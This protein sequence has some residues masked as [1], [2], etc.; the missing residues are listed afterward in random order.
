MVPCDIRVW[1]SRI[2]RSLVDLRSD[3][4]VES[5]IHSKTIKSDRPFAILLHQYHKQF[6]LCWLSSCLLPGS[7]LNAA[8]MMDL[9]SVE[10]PFEQA[11]KKLLTIGFQ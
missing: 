7:I 3:V 4:I 6:M 10:R 11:L 1:S 2:A 8:R 9:A 5:P